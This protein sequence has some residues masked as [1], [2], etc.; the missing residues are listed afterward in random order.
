MDPDESQT[1]TLKPKPHT[2]HEHPKPRTRYSQNSTFGRTR[3]NP[4][5]QSLNS[6]PLAGPV[7]ALDQKPRTK[8]PE[9]EHI[10]LNRKPGIGGVGGSRRVADRRDVRQLRARGLQGPQVAPRN[11]KP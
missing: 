6:Q 3:V 1:D 7:G 2:T 8:N 4:K 11:P 10:F 5:R 9:P